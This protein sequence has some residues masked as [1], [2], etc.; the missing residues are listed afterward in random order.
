MQKKV[1]IFLVIALVNALA[2]FPTVQLFKAVLARG[3]EP[4]RSFGLG[5]LFPF[6]LLTR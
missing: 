5:F 3:R 6:S 2:N 4:W 1:A